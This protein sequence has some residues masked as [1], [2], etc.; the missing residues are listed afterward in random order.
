MP[1]P[2]PWVPRSAT[3]PPA[4]T[5]LSPNVVR[6]ARS[7][8]ASPHM[9]ST[10]L[11]ADFRGLKDKLTS[12][13]RTRSSSKSQE[14]EIGSPVLISSTVK[15]LNLVPLASYR[16]ST[17]ST[18][19]NSPPTPIATS[20]P[21][22]IRKGFS[23]LG[24][25]PVNPE[26]D[27][28]FAREET[29]V[30]KG[31]PLKRRRTHVPSTIITSEFKLD[32]SRNRANSADTRRTQ[33]YLFS[34][35]P[36]LSS[37][38]LQE[39]FEPQIQ[40]AGEA[41]P[42]LPVV[43]RPISLAPPRDTERPT[44]SHGGLRSPCIRQVTIDKDLPELP[45]YL[46]PAALFACHSPSAH[47]VFTKEP[48]EE[49]LQ[50]QML[51][52]EED[53]EVLGDLISHYE[54]K[55]NSH[56]STW[57]SDSLTYS[58]PPSDEEGVLS[59][60]FSSFTSNCSE[61]SSPQRLSI[62]YSYIEKDHFKHTSTANEDETTVDEATPTLNRQTNS[63]PQL[64]NLGISTFGSDLFNL[65]IQHAES[66]PRRHAA[67]FGLGF[68]YSLPEDETTSK[69]TITQD[70]LQPE[71]SVQRESSMSQLNGLLDEFTFLG[72]AII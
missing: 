10:P 21:V 67:C 17:V 16:S 41:A 33:H 30:Q 1:L 3:F 46:T 71:P 24:S 54:E 5:F 65:D 37:P 58:Y 66:T 69:I 56:F 39:S 25:H 61:P 49:Y 13:R 2:S 43:Q 22:T 53:D 9:P 36:W 60:T 7:A 68:Q 15:D 59:P 45:R 6:H 47:E 34:N 42:P 70:T 31:V 26:R 11:F 64:D 29:T 63:P 51:E 55:S 72:E 27:L 38:K 35:D 8:S 40:E 28:I 48:L 18:S 14:L 57:S 19:R 50:E 20:L 4:D 62:Q 52:E 12:K 44:S 23:P 32:H